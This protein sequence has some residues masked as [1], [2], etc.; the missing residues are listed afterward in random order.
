MSFLGDLFSCG[1][2]RRTRETSTEPL[3][4]N[5][6]TP[7][8][9]NA[10]G[11]TATTDHPTIEK[12]NNIL[13]SNEDGIERVA[14]Q[15]RA[16]VQPDVEKRGSGLTKD[17]DI[18]LAVISEKS[19]PTTGWMVEQRVLVTA[20]PATKQDT[21]VP[22]PEQEPEEK[23]EQEHETRAPTPPVRCA[24][25]EQEP[26]NSTP[27]AQAAEP[28]V[29]DIAISNPVQC[30]T[31]EPETRATTPDVTA[32]HEQTSEQ[33]ITLVQDETLEPALAEPASSTV[34]LDDAVEHVPTS[35]KSAPVQLLDLPPGMSDHSRLPHTCTNETQ[36]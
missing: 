6:A 12:P 18:E 32:V 5:D 35:K 33:A 11:T 29:S 14:G 15:V 13:A 26:W 30:A 10:H 17:G 22:E 23:H 24:T 8:P 9:V 4:T 21:S 3:E 7:E 34:E 36:R 19:K 16:D 2:A 25:P 27:V 20:T 31:P 28:E 1:R